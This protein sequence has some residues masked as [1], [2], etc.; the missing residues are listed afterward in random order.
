VRTL[1]SGSTRRAAEQDAAMRAFEK[2]R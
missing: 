2:I 1:G